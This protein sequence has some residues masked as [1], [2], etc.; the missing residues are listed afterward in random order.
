M[1]TD[2]TNL[3]PTIDVTSAAA[4]QITCAHGT[5]FVA[6]TA[7]KMT[8]ADAIPVAQ[9]YVEVVT[10]KSED[11]ELV[12]DTRELVDTESEIAITVQAALIKARGIANALAK[13]QDAP[14]VRLA[15][16]DRGREYTHDIRWR[17]RMLGERAE[18]ADTAAAVAAITAT[19]EVA[20]EVVGDDAPQDV[21]V[22]ETM[23]EINERA[24]AKADARLKE[25]R[26]RSKRARRGAD[27]SESGDVA[28]AVEA[29]RFV[30]PAVR[31]EKVLGQKEARSAVEAAI[32][33][34]QAVLLIGHT[35]TGKTS[36]IR[37]MAF[38]SKR[39]FTRVNLN[40]QT[41]I[42]EFVGRWLVKDGS[43]V[44]Q[45]GVLVTAM[46]RGEW[47]VC[48]EINAALPEILFVLQSLLDDDRCVRLVEKDG[49]VILPHPDFRFFATMNPSDEYAGTKA[50]N[51]ALRNRHAVK[52][53]VDYPSAK[54]ESDILQKRAG[55]NA[56]DAI[57]MVDFANAIRKAKQGGLCYEIVSTRDLLNWAMLTVKMGDRARA[58]KY[59]ILNGLEDEQEAR[60]FR[61]ALKKVDADYAAFV[62]T[63]GIGV[64]P[65]GLIAEV[66]AK[67]ADL[68]RA[69]DETKELMARVEHA[70][71]ERVRQAE[72]QAAMELARAARMVAE[73]E[74]KVRE[75]E[76]R[77]SKIKERIMKRLA[78][79]IAAEGDAMAEDV[80]E[81]GS[82]ATT[83]AIDLT[84]A[85][86][87][88]AAA[89][90]DDSAPF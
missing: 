74:A 35:G 55:V 80:A 58:F 1:T 19:E 25:L 75:A 31:P 70:T 11:G 17:E 20:A 76:V 16:L 29:P 51:R 4:A 33:L 48:D 59:A 22:G 77:E 26:G 37:E 79:I 72:E 68:K 89:G 32:E 71:K 28:S 73:A 86:A 69:E 42:D 56:A 36:L 46:K 62:A 53:K 24:A 81:A 34:S 23:A 47:L 15:T 7:E 41:S 44:W 85:E 2:N 18:A 84:D 87:I 50:L 12:V 5:T 39:A 78:G 54:T 49:E 83:E 14:T 52:V 64:E 9:A 88:L 45:D 6:Y 63:H 61:D 90:R 13:K 21:A 8:T 40:G 60:F 43:T 30:A 3:V 57:I 38:D 66:S 67:L 65:T 82:I 10:L 27:E